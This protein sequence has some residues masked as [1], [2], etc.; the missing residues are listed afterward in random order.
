M[1]VMV[2]LTIRREGAVIF[3]EIAARAQNWIWLA[4][5]AT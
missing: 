5:W 3:E 1:E 2:T 4:C